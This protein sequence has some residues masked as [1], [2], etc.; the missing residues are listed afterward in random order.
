MERP[1]GSHF[2]D[3]HYQINTYHQGSYRVADTIVSSNSVENLGL[4]YAWSQP[5][6]PQMMDRHVNDTG[7]IQQHPQFHH[8]T[9]S[10]QYL[11]HFHGE[12]AYVAPSG[13]LFQSPAFY[14]TDNS[15]QP[16]NDTSDGHIYLAPRDIPR[17]DYRNSLHLVPRTVAD[18]ITATVSN[19]PPGS[20]EPGPSMISLP[21]SR[22]LATDAVSDAAEKRRVNPHRF[23]CQYCDRGFT[24]RH[25]YY[26]HLGAHNDERPFSCECGSAFT[27]KSDLKRHMF[28]SK[29]H[30]NGQF[31]STECNEAG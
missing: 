15:V 12:Q 1:N 20:S 18:Y 5:A 16:F 13:S 26:R 19:I 9:A 14:S 31:H 29:K 4:P 8:S 30:G 27:T 21:A 23:F 25:N 22:Q 6:I 28:K 7:H 24:A 3:G 10:S 11:Q 2:Q 17:T